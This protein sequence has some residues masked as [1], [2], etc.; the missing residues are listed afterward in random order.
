[1]DEIKIEFE[2]YL[3]ELFSSYSIASFL[4]SDVSAK[5]RDFNFKANAKIKELAVKYNIPE[6]SLKIDLSHLIVVYHGKVVIP[7]L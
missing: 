1:M 6:I 2:D 7:H 3:K 4:L 5:S